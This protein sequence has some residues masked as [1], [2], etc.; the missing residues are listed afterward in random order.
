M[1]LLIGQINV[2]KK[3]TYVSL[4]QN[5]KLSYFRVELFTRNGQI[6]VFLD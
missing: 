1:T 4:L 3:E 6:L 2:L 5:A